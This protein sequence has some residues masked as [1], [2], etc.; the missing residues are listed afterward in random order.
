MDLCS[1]KHMEEN[2]E[3]AMTEKASPPQSGKT[4]FCAFNQGSQARAAPWS[5]GLEALSTSKRQPALR[6]GLPVWGL[7]ISSQRA[8]V[9]PSW[10]AASQCWVTGSQLHC[11]VICCCPLQRA[12]PLVAPLY[13]SRWDLLL[14]ICVCKA[15][16]ES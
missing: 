14:W 1:E 4:R 15:E 7:G 9:C 11:T 12:P 10:S 2:P 13:S 16:L 6:A 8:S 5:A 3:L